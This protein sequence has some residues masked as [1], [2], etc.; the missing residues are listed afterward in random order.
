MGRAQGKLHV[1][2][3][4]KRLRA[5]DCIATTNLPGQ[6][7]QGD[8]ESD[9]SDEI[10]DLTGAPNGEGGE[11]PQKKKRKRRKNKKKKRKGVAAE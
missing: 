6:V 4:P 10:E 9:D 1:T 7:L 11:A 2:N 8:E 5:E 3:N